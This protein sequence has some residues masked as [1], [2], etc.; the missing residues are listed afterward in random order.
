MILIFWP[1]LCG[2][3]N[4]IWLQELQSHPSYLFSQRKCSQVHTPQLQS[5]LVVGVGLAH[6]ILNLPLDYTVAFNLDYM[7][8]EPRPNW[9]IIFLHS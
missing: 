7:K 5:Q 9:L 4:Q 8:L 3:S 2:L 1:A 6:K